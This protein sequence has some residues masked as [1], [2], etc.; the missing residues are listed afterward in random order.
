MDGRVRHAA[1]FLNGGGDTPGPTP[2]SKRFRVASVNDRLV[3][4]DEDG[5]V[6]AINL[7]SAGTNAQVAFVS[8]SVESISLVV[9]QSLA[10]STVPQLHGAQVTCV[11][12]GDSDLM[13]YTFSKSGYQSL[14]LN[15]SANNGEGE[16]VTYLPEAYNL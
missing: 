3:V 16:F 7:N 11:K 8:G 2:A 14:V 10:L 6:M 4:V 12:T 13:T 9:A 15:W 1:G 5:V